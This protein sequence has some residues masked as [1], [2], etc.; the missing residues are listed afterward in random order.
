[1]LKRVIFIGIGVVVLIVVIFSVFK[2]SSGKS[3]Q[4]TMVKVERGQI[5]DKALAIG[6]LVPK[7]E[8]AVKSKI[9][10]IVKKVFVE[11]GDKVK[12]GDPLIDISPSPTPLEF[13][14][15]KRNVGM[16]EVAF[17]NSEKEYQRAKTLLEKNLISEEDFD[18]KKKSFDEAKL[19]LQL[20]QEKLSLIEEG[21]IQIAEKKIESVIKSPITGTV[22][23]RKVNEGDPVVPLTS[24]QEGTEL[25]TM[26]YMDDLVFKGTVDEI[27]V[28]KLNEGM[29]AEIKVGAIP[30]DTV[31]GVLYKISP[32]A[33]K[34]ENA[35]LFD[36]ELKIT[37]RG[38]RMLRA[39]YSANA[40]II[41]NKKEDILLIPERLV[42]FKEDS[43]FVE[44]KGTNGEVTKKPIKTGLSD[45]M[46]IEVTEGLEEG[47]Q[48]VQRP[49]KEIK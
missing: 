17:Q 23:E 36:V 45:G 44:I 41:I 38:E 16:V 12:K 21:K 20:G 33:K 4:L 6:T 11:I 31:E 30:N 43:V 35:T 42:E 24:Y 8:I 47:D 28:G 1:M 18:Q 40:D 15:A 19:R 25:M 3:N 32:K 34:E 5:V 27:D 22:L 10:G 29:N 37:R 9:S 46:N 48:I 2:G 26:A 14:E 7:N 13:A 49:P 39:G